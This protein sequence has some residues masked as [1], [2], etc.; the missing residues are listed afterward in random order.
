MHLPAAINAHGS[1]YEASAL[2]SAIRTMGDALSGEALRTSCPA[3]CKFHG[4]V[5]YRAAANRSIAIGSAG[6]LT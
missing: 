5:R 4:R 2:E 6:T 1:N 3:Q